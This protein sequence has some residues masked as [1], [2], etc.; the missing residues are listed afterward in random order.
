MDLQC[1]VVAEF[2]ASVVRFAWDS[3]NVERGDTRDDHHW[4]DLR[5]MA[6]MF[7]RWCR[8]DMR[9]VRRGANMDKQ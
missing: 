7:A 2:D 9:A 4:N 5:D 8:L 1:S 6:A 3:T